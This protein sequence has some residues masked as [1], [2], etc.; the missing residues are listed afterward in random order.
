MSFLRDAKHWKNIWMPQI[1]Q[2]SKGKSE[3]A[4]N[5]KQSGFGIIQFLWQNS[6]Q[7]DSR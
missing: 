5:T 6:A 4:D 7:L 3:R 1:P 2:K